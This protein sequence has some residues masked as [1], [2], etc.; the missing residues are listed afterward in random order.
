MVRPRRDARP[1]AKQS[2][3]RDRNWRIFKLRGLWWNVGMLT[4]KRLTAARR[5]IDAEL[6]HLGAESSSQRVE[7]ERRDA[8]T[9]EKFRAELIGDLPVY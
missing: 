6:E 5:A 7:R 3:A 2:A 9:Y 1:T 8:E 4:G